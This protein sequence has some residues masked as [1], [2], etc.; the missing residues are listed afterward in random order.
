MSFKE[1]PR[2]PQCECTSITL[3]RLA[4]T[5]TH[6]R[7]GVCMLFKHSGDQ[8]K[9]DNDYRLMTRNQKFNLGL[10]LTVRKVQLQRRE[11]YSDAKWVV[12]LVSTCS[13]IHTSCNKGVKWQCFSNVVK[14]TKT[15]I[16]WTHTH[17]HTLLSLWISFSSCKSVQVKN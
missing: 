2:H 16:I 1:E 11:H 4:R 13:F 5:A 7:S 6:D 14:S 9:E 12:I 10:K 15:P 3:W 17:I 8:A